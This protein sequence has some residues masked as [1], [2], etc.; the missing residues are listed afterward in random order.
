MIDRRSACPSPDQ[1]ILFLQ[2]HIIRRRDVNRQQPF[3]RNA[4]AGACVQDV[5]S[6]RGG[7]DRRRR[8]VDG[9][10]WGIVL[11]R[12]GFQCMKIPVDG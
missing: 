1:C 4:G 10:A 2:R 7:R 9:E 5:D 8:G 12:R 11:R 3:E 6:G